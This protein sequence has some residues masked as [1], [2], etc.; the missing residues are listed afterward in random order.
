MEVRPQAQVIRDACAHINKVN[1]RNGEFGSVNGRYEVAIPNTGFWS[2]S[3]YFDKD[4]YRKI[5]VIYSLQMPI[6][7]LLRKCL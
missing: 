2:L 7:A 6:P 3:K 1:V 5:P 4:H